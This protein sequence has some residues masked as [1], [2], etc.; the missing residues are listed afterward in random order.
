MHRPTIETHQKLG[1]RGYFT[2][3]SRPWKRGVNLAAS[4]VSQPMGC[5]LSV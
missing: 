3:Q 5:L 1:Q 2:G 4:W